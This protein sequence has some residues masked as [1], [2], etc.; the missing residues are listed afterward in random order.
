MFGTNGIV[1]MQQIDGFDEITS[2]PAVHYIERSLLLGGTV[3]VTQDTD[4][5]I[6]PWL[7]EIDLG[8]ERIIN[9]PDKCMF[10]GIRNS[11]SLIRELRGEFARGAKPLFFCSTQ[12][13]TWF[14]E[15][16]G[17]SWEQT[18]SCDPDVADYF[19]RKD[20]LRLI[21]ERIGVANHFPPYVI[22]RSDWKLRDLQGAITQVRRKANDL[23]LTDCVMV[24]RTD[25]ASGEGMCRVGAPEFRRFVNEYAGRDLIVE[26]EIWPNKPLSVQWFVNKGRFA[27]VGS[28]LQMV[29]GYERVGDLIASNDR[30]LPSG[31]VSKLQ[32]L[33]EP[34]VQYATA[35]EYNGVIGFDAV[36]DRQSDTVFLTEANAR[37]TAATYPFGLAKRLGYP[38]WA[39]ADKLMVPSLGVETFDDVKSLLGSSLLFNPNRREGVVP[40]MVGALR[41]PRRRLGLMA[42]ASDPRH[43]EQTLGEA[44]KRLTS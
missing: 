4:L 8:P 44:Q 30:I 23:R 9:I 41:H 39:I 5:S 14:I 20:C 18:V 32:A 11:P 12:L 43:A 27:Y 17:L 16:F 25:L 42:V 6:V 35:M 10:A 37:V 36:W 15:A 28:S 31:I 3:C 21:A 24:K 34:L 33:S 22:L 26:A 1:H 38:N 7:G 19:G 40:Y 29:E 2:V 13:E